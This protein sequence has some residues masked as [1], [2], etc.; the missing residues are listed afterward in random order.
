MLFFKKDRDKLKELSADSLHSSSRIDFLATTSKRL[1]LDVSQNSEAILE[2]DDKCKANAEFWSD[3][4]ERLEIEI[5]KF[6]NEIRDQVD[7]LE[8]SNSSILKMQRAIITWIIMLSATGIFS[9]LLYWE[10]I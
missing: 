4:H 3:A 2:V 6:A 5:S 7:K 8:S 10:I 1:S 9:F